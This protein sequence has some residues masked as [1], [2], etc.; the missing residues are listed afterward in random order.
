MTEKVVANQ[1]FPPVN[2]TFDNVKR[3]HSQRMKYVDHFFHHVLV[4]FVLFKTLWNHFVHFFDLKE[5]TFTRYNCPESILNRR[6][7]FLNFF[8][9]FCNYWTIRL[10]GQVENRLKE[11]LSM[12]VR[13]HVQIPNK[14]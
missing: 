11:H 8:D 1:R 9:F 5:T 12:V 13:D 7:L 10:G 14:Q 2:N 3:K 6:L 4:H